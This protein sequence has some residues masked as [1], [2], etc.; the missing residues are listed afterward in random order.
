MF[1]SSLRR[2]IRSKRLSIQTVFLTGFPFVCSRTPGATIQ[3]WQGGRGLGRP[4]QGGGISPGPT[5]QGSN[6]GVY[7]AVL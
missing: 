2:N 1:H 6:G 7:I 3:R 5:W 4:S